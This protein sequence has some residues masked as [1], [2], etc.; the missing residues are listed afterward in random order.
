MNF[1]QFVNRK[2]EKDKVRSSV[3]D[4]DRWLLDS[5]LT[6]NALPDLVKST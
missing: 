2:K 3:F 1:E 5:F 4:K 6:C